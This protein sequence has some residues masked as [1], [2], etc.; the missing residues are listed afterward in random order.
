[1]H[2]SCL[3]AKADLGL[4][5]TGPTLLQTEC[6]KQAKDRPCIHQIENLKTILIQNLPC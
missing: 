6:I 2:F 5:V 4:K 3:R 1:M